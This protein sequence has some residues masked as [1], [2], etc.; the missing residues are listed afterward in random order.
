MTGLG[1]FVVPKALEVR[2][3]DG[4]R[5]G[6]AGDRV[7]LNLG[8][9]AAIPKVAGLEEAKPLTHIEALDLDYAPPPLIILAGAT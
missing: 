8:T 3:N 2:L 1:R 4:G 7:F 9:Q 5:R 6:L